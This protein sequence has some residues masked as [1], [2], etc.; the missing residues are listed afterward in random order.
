MLRQ[1]FPNP[2]SKYLIFSYIF[3]ALLYRVLMLQIHVFDVATERPTGISPIGHPGASTALRGI[4]TYDMRLLSIRQSLDATPTNQITFSLS[5]EQ[6]L[7]Y[8]AT[9]LKQD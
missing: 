3:L 5:T 1:K 6:E 8:P 9:V 7:T 2:E 4:E